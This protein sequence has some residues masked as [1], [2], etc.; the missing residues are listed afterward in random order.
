[1]GNLILNKSG[2][3]GNPDKFI[4]ILTNN[5][6]FLL[7]ELGIRYRIVDWLLMYMHIIEP[8]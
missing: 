7:K 4:N 1:M 3:R 5:L 8:D 2:L 6:L